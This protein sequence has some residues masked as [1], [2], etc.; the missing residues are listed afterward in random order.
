MATSWYSQAKTRLDSLVGSDS[1]AKANQRLRNALNN[2][3]ALIFEPHPPAQ[4][5]QGQLHPRWAG[6]HFLYN[7]PLIDGA[8]P[9]ASKSQLLQIMDRMPKGAH[10]HIHFNSTLP[11]EFLLREAARQ[12]HMR[13]WSTL[14]LTS[15][16]NLDLCEIQFS[17]LKH[18]EPG[19]SA[20]KHG[21]SAIKY[22][23]EPS[24]AAEAQDRKRDDARQKMMYSDFRSQWTRIHQSYT[25]DLPA[26]ADDEKRWASVKDLLT[27]QEWQQVRPRIEPLGFEEWLVTKLVFDGDEVYNPHQDQCG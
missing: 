6:D 8:A 2:D 11:P 9:D 23:G 25:Q 12:P 5:W 19:L 21:Y 10:L 20:F 14:P 22:D 24:D 1:V 13:I 7:Q 3:D 17:I 26:G 4:G 16:E 18:D 27:Y 15:C